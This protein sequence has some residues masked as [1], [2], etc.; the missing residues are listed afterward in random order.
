M[1]ILAIGR[2]EYLLNTLRVLS[3]SHQIV[4]V[5]TGPATDESLAKEEDFRKF[6]ERQSC[7]YICSS[8]IDNSVLSFCDSVGADVAV[9]VNWISVIGSQFIERFP[10]GV[11]N[12]H[13]GD[14][15]EYRGNAILNWAILRGE[16]ELTISVH[17][18]MAG[19]LDVGDV[20]A[21]RSFLLNKQD[22]VGDLVERLGSEI[23]L[24]YS[25]ALGN[26]ERGVC[27]RDYSEV[28]LRQGF[29]CYP[30]LPEDGCIEWSCSAVEIDKLVRAS[31]RPYPGAFTVLMYKGE[32]R[33]LIVWSSRVVCDATL[34]VG[35]PGHVIWNDRDSGETHVYT[36]SGVLALRSVQWV[37]GEDFRPGEYFKSI[38]MRFGLSQ[39]QLIELLAFR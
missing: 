35:V 2:S 32:L 14:I 36:G 37:G 25:Q 8:V 38:R 27:L 16:K 11:L 4:G 29:R 17:K 7:G 24:A 22:S 21:R 28:L 5:I 6:A 30:R 12:A 3:K 34:D 15:P 23:P 33:K 39:G 10:Q 13:C 19:E 9:S 26:L 31:S 1:K 18:M 20:Y